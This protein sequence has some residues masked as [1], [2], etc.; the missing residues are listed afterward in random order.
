MFIR[1]HNGYK[2]RIYT[3]NRDKTVIAVS[4]FAGR[5]VKGIAKCDPKDAPDLEK[6]IKLA[7]LRCDEKIA[8]KKVNR[9]IMKVKAAKTELEAA[10]KKFSH[11][12]EYLNDSQNKLLKASKELFDFENSL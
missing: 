10:N 2:Y 6:G 5:T 9:G 8:N 4:S 3:A 7:I 11:M 1:E 12:Q